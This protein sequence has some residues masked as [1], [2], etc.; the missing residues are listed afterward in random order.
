MGAPESRLAFQLGYFVERYLENNNLGIPYGADA[1]LRI[2][3]GAVRLPD[4]SFVK[5]SD[6]TD[7]SELKKQVP[8]FVPSLAVEILSP[9]NTR[10]EMNRK[11]REYFSAGTQ[12][13]WEVEPH[14]RLVRVYSDADTFTIVDELGT[15]T[16][17]DVLPGFSLSIKTWFDR[18]FRGR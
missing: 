16:A 9:S 15:L 3:P 18:A 2:L 8:H 17:K 12:I 5:W 1:T 13:V 14:G 10:A 11:R 6:V 7:P 4:F